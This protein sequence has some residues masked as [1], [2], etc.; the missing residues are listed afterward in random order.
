MSGPFFF[1]V[2]CIGPVVPATAQ[3]RPSFGGS[4]CL[5]QNQN[6]PR[7]SEHPP[8]RGKKSSVFPP[9]ALLMK[10]FP[11]APNHATDSCLVRRL[12]PQPHSGKCIATAFFPILIYRQIHVNTILTHRLKLSMLVFG[13]WIYTYGTCYPY[14]PVTLTV[15]YMHCRDDINS[16]Y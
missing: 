11:V 7:P 5:K 10:F 14:H 6:A 13:L 4:C 1:F 12:L 9:L 8:V 3:S 16:F 15:P 2:L